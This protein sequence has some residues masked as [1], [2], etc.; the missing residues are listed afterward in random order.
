MRQPTKKELIIAGGVLATLLLVVLLIVLF[1]PKGVT[2]ITGGCSPTNLREVLTACEHDCARGYSDAPFKD[3]N[4]SCRTG[5]LSAIKHV[6]A[7]CP[8]S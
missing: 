1:K 3:K 5:C 4:A 7:I 6:S 8:G 2:L